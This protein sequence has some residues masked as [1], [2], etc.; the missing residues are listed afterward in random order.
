MTQKA[1]SEPELAARGAPAATNHTDHGLPKLCAT[2]RWTCWSPVRPSFLCTHR[3]HPYIFGSLAV[4][5]LCRSVVGK[6]AAFCGPFARSRPASS[7]P[8][9]PSVRGGWRGRGSAVR[10]E[11][12]DTSRARRSGLKGHCRQ[13]PAHAESVAARKPEIASATSSAASRGERC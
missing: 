13:S 2:L 6:E 9:R 8:L 12:S 11:A 3:L 7:L 10:H 4:R 1:L 5:R